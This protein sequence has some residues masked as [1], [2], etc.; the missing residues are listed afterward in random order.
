MG[1]EPHILILSKSQSAFPEAKGAHIPHK[2]RTRKG[3]RE[4]VSR[5]CLASCP[6]TAGHWGKQCHSYWGW[7]LPACVGGSSLSTQ[8]PQEG[9][10]SP[11]LRPHNTLRWLLLGQ[12]AR[13]L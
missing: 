8:Q 4:G 2:G 3:R 5:L 7:H 12:E 11:S 9:P 6:F 1:F 10:A 13:C